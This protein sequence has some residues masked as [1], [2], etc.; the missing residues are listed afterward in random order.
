MWHSGLFVEFQPIVWLPAGSVYG[1]EALGRGPAAPAVLLDE[2]ARRGTL[3]ELDYEWRRAAIRAVAEEPTSA[4]LYFLNVDTR[5][6][7]D[8]EFAAGGTLA[9]LDRERLSPGRFVLELSERGAALASS[10]VEAL[11][12]HYRQ[13]GFRVALDDLGAGYSALT[14]VVRARPDVLKL[15]MELVRD[16]G[17][18]PLRLEL[19]RA[20]AQF[21]SRAG[22]PLIA[23]GVEAWSEVTA[24]IS[25]GVRLAQ[26]YLLARPSRRPLPPSAEVRETLLRMRASGPPERSWRLSS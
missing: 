13:Q 14:T 12:E 10:R 19:V 17:H 24:L 16:L 25:V 9:L 6:I 1:Y 7:D 4:A 11:A 3:R 20:L 22:V 26:G 8:P 21:S 23:E 5:L 18:D 2:A 15:D